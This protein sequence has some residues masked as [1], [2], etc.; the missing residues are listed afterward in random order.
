[1][2][3]RKEKGLK[4]GW[5]PDKEQPLKEGSRKWRMIKER[6]KE[7]L[8][9]EQQVMLERKQLLEAKAATPKQLP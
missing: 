9:E 1:M 2:Q 3:E 6:E 7:V 5:A 4:E 8:E